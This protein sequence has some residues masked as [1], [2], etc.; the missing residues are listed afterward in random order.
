MYGNKVENTYKVEKF[1][2]HAKLNISLPIKQKLK[3]FVEIT[4]R[5]CL[6][7]ML[8]SACV[9]LASISE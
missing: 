1:K 8:C 3:M 6:P 7:N 4:F 9:C 5:T 2:S